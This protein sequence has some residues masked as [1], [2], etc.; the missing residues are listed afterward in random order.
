METPTPIND[1][2][3]T[4]DMKRLRNGSQQLF[5]RDYGD[6][7]FTDSSNADVIL[8]PPE[9]HIYAELIDGVWHWV[10]GCAECNGHDRNWMTYIECDKHNVCRTCKTPR[11]QLTETPWG[12]RHGW[13][14]K[15]CADA[16]H[17][18]DKAAALAAMPEEYL[19]LDYWREDTPRCPYCNFELR[20]ESEDISGMMDS[21]QEQ[22]CP[23]CDHVFTIE[24]ECSISYTT[25]RK[26]EGAS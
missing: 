3:L 18:A 20:V 13:Q 14:C 12:G 15:P 25:R 26:A 4:P 22:E 1:E 8:Q 5:R 9:R 21:E 2:R 7:R 11:N 19:E 23:R 16:E 24:A 17:E 6:N 10:N